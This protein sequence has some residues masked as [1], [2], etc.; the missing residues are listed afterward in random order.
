M[1]KKQK[2]Y[3]PNEIAKSLSFFRMLVIY[4]VLC[5]IGVSVLIVSFNRLIRSHDKRLTENICSLVTEKMNNSISYMTSSAENMSAVLSAQHYD[6][7]QKIP[8]LEFIQFRRRSIDH[9]LFINKSHADIAAAG[10]M[11]R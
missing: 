2:L 4:L 5:S 9:F 11:L 7:F 8:F 10:G 6:G 1:K 3:L